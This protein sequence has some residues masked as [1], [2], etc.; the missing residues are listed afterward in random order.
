MRNQNPIRPL[1]AAVLADANGYEQGILESRIKRGFPTYF[2]LRSGVVV[3]ISWSQSA[4]R[5][6]IS[7]SVCEAWA[8]NAQVAFSLVARMNRMSDQIEVAA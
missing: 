1:P 2:R 4:R 7:N 6:L 3:R 8:N 5:F